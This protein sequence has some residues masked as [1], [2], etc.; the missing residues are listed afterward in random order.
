MTGPSL[1]SARCQ[2]TA[3]GELFNRTRVFDRHRVG[4]YAKRGEWAHS[5]RCL[6]P[7]EM[8][9]R[10]WRRNA[11]GFWVMDALDAAGQART[12]GDAGRSATPAPDKPARKAVTV[13]PAPCGVR[14]GT[15]G[16]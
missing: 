12:R 11:A 1:G 8:Q 15:H 16:G 9:A 7:A 3:C 14:R 13:Y 10:G 6:T 2:C 5:R 4:E